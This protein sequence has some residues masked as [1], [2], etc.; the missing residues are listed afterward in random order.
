M[1]NTGRKMFVDEKRGVFFRRRKHEE[2]F[3]DEN[4]FVLDE[5]HTKKNFC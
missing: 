1:K 3:V 5:K 2:I 4:E